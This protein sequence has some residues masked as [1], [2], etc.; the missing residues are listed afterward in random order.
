MIGRRGEF[1]V[2][3]KTIRHSPAGNPFVSK[4][5]FRSP[6]PPAGTSAKACAFTCELSESTLYI[7]KGDLPLLVKWNVQSTF[8]PALTL[9]KENVLSSA[10]GLEPSLRSLSV[11][12]EKFSFVYVN[13]PM[14]LLPAP[15]SGLG[16]ATM[17]SAPAAT[18]SF[19]ADFETT[20]LYWRPS[21][22]G[23]A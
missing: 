21:T 23:V 19:S 8:A 10:I 11:S 4:V 3:V 17:A 15:S 20:A 2:K 1:V 13:I 16:S 9:P 6:L 12:D 22:S 14:R 18:G 7:L 5:T